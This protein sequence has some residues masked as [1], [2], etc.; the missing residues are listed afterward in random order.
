[1]SFGTD[2]GEVLIP[3]VVNG[4]VVSDA[5]AIANYRRTGQHLGIFRTPEE[6]TAYAQSLHR[7]QAREYGGQRTFVDPATFREGRMSSG[8]RTPEG[9]RAVGGVPNSRHLFGD[10]ADFVPAQG[11]S[12]RELY[13][14]AR[15]H[16]PGAHILNEGDHVH[17]DQRGFGRV[18][19][20]GRR[21]AM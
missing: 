2:Q 10:A 6:A 16:F 12:M 9:N 4:R 11:Q 13:L 5:E 19:Y 3:T 17:V 20:F 8:R 1:M 14:Q 18:P 21:G 15:Q 7:D